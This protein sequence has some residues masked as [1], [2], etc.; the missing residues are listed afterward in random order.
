MKNLLCLR[1]Q[2][3]Y[4]KTTMLNKSLTPNKEYHFLCMPRRGTRRNHD[5]KLHEYT[6]R[7]SSSDSG[8]M[9]SATK[10]K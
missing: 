6:E 9:S 5:L 1:Q 8:T 4:S 2:V 7:D 3:Q 10:R